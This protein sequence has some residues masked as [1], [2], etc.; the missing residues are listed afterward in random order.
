MADRGPPVSLV[1]LRDRR[2]DAIQ[3]LSDGFAADLL[4]VEEFESRLALVHGAGTMSEIEAVVADLPPLPAGVSS[5]ALAPLSVDRAL[6]APAPR[7]RSLLGNVERRGGWVVPARL[8]VRVA[9]GNLEL[10]FRNARFTAPVTELH[11]RVMF[12]N[13]EMIVPPQLAVDCEASSI[14]GNVESHGTAAVPDPDRPLL[15]IRGRAV[16]GNIEIHTYLPGETA[17][18]WGRRRIREGR[19]LPAKERTPAMG[20]IRP[21]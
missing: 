3:Q 14:L 5:T 18:D 15:R 12:G 11:A 9:F 19:G 17:H 1:A 4:S 2:E 16:L 6:A 21:E 8:E 13:L 7:L 20:P 10:D